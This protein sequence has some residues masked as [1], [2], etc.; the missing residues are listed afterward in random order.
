MQFVY[1]GEAGKE[2]VELDVRAHEH[3]FKVRR[4]QTSA[5]VMLRNLTDHGLYRYALESLGKKEASLVLL[6]TKELPCVPQ[7]YLHL[8][9][10]VVDPKVIEKHLPLLNELGVAR[11][12][13]VYGDFSQRTHR[14]DEARMER[15]IIN[16]CQQCGR[17]DKMVVEQFDSV[18]T[19]LKHF[20][21]MGVIDFEPTVLLT[22]EVSIPLLIGPE[23]GFSAKERTLFK[24]HSVYGLAC[25]S[26]LRSETAVVSVAAKLLA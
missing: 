25:R 13:F 18:P 5:E 17:S 15:I 12:S 6:E 7:R 22:P 2:R 24:Q 10:C 26:I 19:V 1:H 9:W 11:L 4:M 16:S 3:L 14:L 23:G 21:Q 8:A 20:P